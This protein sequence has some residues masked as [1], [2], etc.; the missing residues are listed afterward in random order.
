MGHNGPVAAHYSK[1]KPKVRLFCLKNIAYF[2]DD[3]EC[4][5]NVGVVLVI[6]VFLICLVLAVRAALR[7]FSQRVQRPSTSTD[8]A[9][10]AASS[11]E[12]GNRLADRDGLHSSPANGTPAADAGDGRLLDKI[13]GRRVEAEDRDGWP[14]VD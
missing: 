3:I 6:L 9:S 8:M 14:H 2:L 13:A 10:F 11:T 1:E 4:M 7:R 12:A 5:A